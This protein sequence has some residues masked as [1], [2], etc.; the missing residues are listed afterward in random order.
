[1]NLSLST[2]LQ[3]AYCLDSLGGK[4]DGLAPE[5]IRAICGPKDLD[6]LMFRQGG[7]ISPQEPLF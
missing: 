6:R 2:R 7:P 4:A 3:S 1:M 5:G